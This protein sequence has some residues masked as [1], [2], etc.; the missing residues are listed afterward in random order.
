MNIKVLKNHVI[1][2]KM[3]REDDCY[4]NA[5][6]EDR[7]ALMWEITAEIWSLRN[8]SDVERRLQKNVANFVEQ[9]G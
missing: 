2:K 9:Q 5:S 1:L 7:I 6:P 8:R 3:S 4:V